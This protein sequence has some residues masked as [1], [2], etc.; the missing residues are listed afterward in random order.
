MPEEI[1][2]SKSDKKKESWLALGEAKWSE[3][4]IAG[5]AVKQEDI[6]FKDFIPKWEKGYAA[7]NMGDYKQ[8]VNLY[9]LN[10]YVVPEFGHLKIS[11]ITTFQLV[12]FFGELKRENGKEFAT[13]SKLN[14]YKA[15]KSVF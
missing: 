1:A 6:T 15:V 12:S 10:K 14:I 9:N 5:K 8:H 4:V 7:G 2:R 3:K 11:K 13:N